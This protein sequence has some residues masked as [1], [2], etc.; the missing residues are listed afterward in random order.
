MTTVSPTLYNLLSH[1]QQ[2]AGMIVLLFWLTRLT[3]AQCSRVL[4]ANS[5]FISN[6]SVIDKAP[7]S[8]FDF[9]MA[10]WSRIV[11]R[12]WVTT[13]AALLSILSVDALRPGLGLLR[14]FEVVA[15]TILVV[16]FD[17]RHTLYL[18]LTMRLSSKFGDRGDI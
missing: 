3:M 14:G 7:C 18:T 4:G 16:G 11:V 6:P 12:I 1:A 13:G 2:I 17:P 10:H 8:P 15:R 9:T 5:T